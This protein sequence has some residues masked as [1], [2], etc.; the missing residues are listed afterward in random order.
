MKK[1]LPLVAFLHFV[2]G[3]F[4]QSEKQVKWKYEVKKIADKV[5]EVHWSASINNGFHMYSQNPGEGAKI[6]ATNFSFVKN[7]LLS[8]DGTVKET[9]N[10]IRKYE[11]VFRSDVRYFEKNAGF[12]QTI[13]LKGNLK[14]T[15]AGNVEFTVCNDR[16]CLPPSIFQFKAGIGE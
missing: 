7:P 4:A 3:A 6:A 15:L 9:G 13:K 12:V 2:T 1:L 5:Y 10:R 16:T 14:T 8:L 11:E